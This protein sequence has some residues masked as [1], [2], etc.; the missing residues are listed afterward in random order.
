MK[1]K[2]NHLS[3][4]LYNDNKVDMSYRQIDAL[5]VLHRWSRM[6]RLF[7]RE[8]FDSMY[9]RIAPCLLFLLICFTVMLVLYMIFF[10]LDHSLLYGLFSD[11]LFTFP[12]HRSSPRSFFVGFMLC[13]VCP[14][15]FC[16]CLS[17]D[18]CLLITSL[19]S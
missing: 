17:F 11:K 9:F 7:Q 4:F 5:P 8:Q 18:L 10:I 6:S 1:R 14:F 3:S 2:E 16:Y 19:V 13:T 15:S 12:Q